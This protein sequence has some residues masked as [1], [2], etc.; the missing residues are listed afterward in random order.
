MDEVWLKPE[1]Q[2]QK[3]PPIGC[4]TTKT[5]HICI[6]SGFCKKWADYFEIWLAG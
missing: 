2:N 4:L 5:M 6:C 1:I 3:W